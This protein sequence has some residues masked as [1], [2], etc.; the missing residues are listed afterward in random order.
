MPYIDPR[1]R[2]AFDCTGDCERQEPNE[3]GELTYVLTQ[4]AL[5]YFQ[6]SLRS[7]SDIAEVMSAFECAKLE[8]WRR[9]GVP[10]EERKREENGDVY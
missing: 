10:H 1:K 9:V 8:F 5:S 3:V 6:R 4:A 2:D 7:F